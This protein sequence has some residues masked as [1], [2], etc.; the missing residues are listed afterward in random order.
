MTANDDSIATRL[1]RRTVLRGIGATGVILGG[2]G[3]VSAAHGEKGGNR[4]GGD[5]HG[6]G[7]SGDRG[8]GGG[9]GGGG[10]SRVT[11][12]SALTVGCELPPGTTFEVPD[13]IEGDT[14]NYWSGCS[15]AEEATAPAR[16]KFQAYAV[17][18]PPDED[19][20]PE[21]YCD[22]IYVKA[23]RPWG[24][25]ESLGEPALYSVVEVT[26]ACGDLDGD[27]VDKIGLEPGVE[28]EEG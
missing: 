15:A 12:G 6:N 18:S 11:G 27:D 16:Q 13:V 1:S 23:G 7:K 22:R 10:A 5:D 17:R 28:G 9:S 8:Q 20:F 4:D 24:T 14:I 21:D 19:P 3:T 2:V 25:S 26:E